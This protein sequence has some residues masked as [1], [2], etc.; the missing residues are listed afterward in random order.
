M[1]KE[2]ETQDTGKSR[3]NTKDQFYTSPSVAKK[4]I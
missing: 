2:K 4:C 1:S 3:T